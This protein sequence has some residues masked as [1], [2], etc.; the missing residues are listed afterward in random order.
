MVQQHHVANLFHLTVSETRTTRRR[1]RQ[2]GRP[3]PDTPY[4]EVTAR[5]L[6]L[7][8]QRDTNAIAQAQQLLG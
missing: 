1:Y 2:R 8:V 6:H 3:G 7:Q 5:Q 4:E